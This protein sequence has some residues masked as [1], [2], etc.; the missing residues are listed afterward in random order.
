MCLNPRCWNLLKPPRTPIGRFIVN[1]PILSIVLAGLIPNI[2][3]AVFNFFYNQ[4]RI[5]HELPHLYAQFDRVQ[6]WINGLAFPI[7]V[8]IGT[9]IA[10]HTKRLVRSSSTPEALEGCGQILTFG[11]FVSLLLLA[12]WVPSGLAFP[13]AVGWDELG[14]LPFTF[15][16][17]FF[18]SLALCG[19][20]ATAYPYFLITAMAT[21][22]LVPAIVR[23]GAIP[24]PRRRDLRRVADLNGVHFI[25][26]AAVPMLGMLLIGLVL[27]LFRG[28]EGQADNEQRW[29]LIA[30]SAG[31]LAWLA[32]V[33]WLRRIID[34]DSAALS[35]IAVDE[36]RGPGG[37]RSGSG[38][39][40][41]G[42][43]SR[44]R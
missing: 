22:F 6:L 19:C 4:Q 5:L 8:V 2:M 40:S 10:L 3:T 1:W 43:S 18:L 27:V 35:E 38:R 37:R 33:M 13:I 9:Q 23:R 12:L 41:S 42:H 14:G 16:L 30:V 28:E 31:G 26:A 15:Y 25:A 17:H 29:P 44:S 21:H 34:L 7:G 24:G 36:S 11:K 39:S 20:A 32:I